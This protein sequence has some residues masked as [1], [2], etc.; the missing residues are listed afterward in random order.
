LPFLPPFPSCE[1]RNG[2]GNLNVAACTNSVIFRLASFLVTRETNP[3]KMYRRVAPSLVVALALAG[4]T[5]TATAELTDPIFFTTPTELGN[6]AQEQSFLQ[7]TVNLTL[8]IG[9]TIANP[10]YG[11]SLTYLAQNPG[12]SGA[13]SITNFVV[14]STGPSNHPN[15]TANVSWNLTDTSFSLAYVLIKDGQGG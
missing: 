7:N 4:L 10:A 6:P 13:V 8:Q 9:G 5:L 3:G 11:S 2:I 1:H 15:A 14:V 12:Q